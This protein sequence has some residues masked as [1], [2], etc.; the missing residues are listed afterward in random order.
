MGYLPDWVVNF[1]TGQHPY[2]ALLA[3]AGMAYGA[4]TQMGVTD[5][6]MVYWI[7]LFTIFSIIFV[8]FISEWTEHNS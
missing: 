6:D 2:A 7:F 3:V 1:I 8:F 4:L 5:S